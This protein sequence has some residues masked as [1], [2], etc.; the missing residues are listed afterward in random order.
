M[1]DL[2]VRKFPI[3][4]E[5][6]DRCEDFL[7]EEITSDYQLLEKDKLYQKPDLINPEDNIRYIPGD[8]PDDKKYYL[9]FV[10]Q[11]INW[12]TNDALKAIARKLRISKKRFSYAGTKD[13]HA[14]TTQI[15]SLFAVKKEDL[16][17]IKVKD[18]KILGSWYEKDKIR[19]GEL[20]GN[21]FTITGNYNIKQPILAKCEEVQSYNQKVIRSKSRILLP[22]YYGTQRF[23][24]NRHNTHIIGYY[25]ITGQFDNAVW[26]YLTFWDGEKNEKATQFRKKISE[27][28]SIENI[29]ERDWNLLLQECPK[30]LRYEKILMSHLSKNPNDYVNAI[31]KLPR[32]ISLMFIHALQSWIFNEEISRRMDDGRL[33]PLENEYV[34]GTDKMGFSDLSKKINDK[35]NNGF[36]VVNIIGYNSKINKYEKEILDSLNLTVH[37]F[38]LK[39]MPELSCKGTYRTF[40]TSVIGL[41]IKKL[42]DDIN[43]EDRTN[44]RNNM[45][46][47]FLAP[48]SYATSVMAQIID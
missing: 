37:M 47:F 41:E 10:L 25:M 46:R 40:M 9:H 24:S 4:W 39:S 33:D 27:F 5:K 29:K 38:K 20:S 18:I 12:S 35:N 31:R 43:N 16:S 6:P 2:S 32:G 48:G 45:I 23:G 44:N 22:N 3:F 19:M 15:A 30:H 1:I 11:K 7:V 36:T 17:T 42:E 26:N 13:R 34:C 21:R 14:V 8:D 28:G